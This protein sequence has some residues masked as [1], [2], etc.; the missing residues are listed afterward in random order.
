[1]TEKQTMA[2]KY[3]VKLAQNNQPSQ[4]VIHDRDGRI[5]DERTYGED[6]EDIPG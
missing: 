3:G 6:P 1:M 2:I 5:R 4:L